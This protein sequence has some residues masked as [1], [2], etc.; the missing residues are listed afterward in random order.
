[1]QAYKYSSFTGIERRKLTVY[2]SP[3][4]T[5]TMTIPEDNNVLGITEEGGGITGIMERI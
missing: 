4:S 2:V 5:E 1:M 3:L